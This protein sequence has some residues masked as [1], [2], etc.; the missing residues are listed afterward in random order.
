MVAAMAGKGVWAVIL[1]EA[2]ILRWSDY[3]LAGNRFRRPSVTIRY[4]EHIGRG[5]AESAPPVDIDPDVIALDNA[6]GR[7]FGPQKAVIWLH[8]IDTRSIKDKIPHPVERPKHYHNLEMARRCWQEAI[9]RM[10]EAK[11]KNE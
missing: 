9:D 4:E 7:L 5:Y 1:T 2:L 8:Y 10:A 11:E 3:V 6:F